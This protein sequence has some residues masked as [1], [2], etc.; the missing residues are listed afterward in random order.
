MGVSSPEIGAVLLGGY[1]LEAKLGAAT[2]HVYRARRQRDGKVVV[3]RLFQP[4]LPLM[5]ADFL[6]LAQTASRIRHPALASVEAYG[7]HGDRSCFIISEFVTGLKLD[8]WADEVGIP[9]MVQVIELVRHV[10]LGLQAAARSGLAHDSLNPR[11]VVVLKP[12]Q[13][14][15]PRMP[16]KLLDLGVPAFL[17]PRE[18]RAQAVRF[19]APE[20][21]LA[22]ASED[23][24]VAFRCT[25]TMNVYSCGCLLYYLCTGGPPYPGATVAELR[26]AHS[27]GR[28]A[29]PLRI[30]P[31]ISP[32]FNTLILRALALEPRERF[33]TV[34]DLAE[35][36]ASVIGTLSA[37]GKGSHPPVSV[38]A[39][40][41][42][43]SPPEPD[44]D[45]PPTFKTVRPPDAYVE[46]HVR[47]MEGDG[48]RAMDRNR[49]ETLELGTMH[50]DD[51]QTMPPGPATDSDAPEAGPP[52]GLFS[53]A[54]PWRGRRS[55]TPP[56]PRRATSDRATPLALFS[57][58]APSM[59]APL[60]II[61]AKA[62]PMTSLLVG[63][64]DGSAVHRSRQWRKQGVGRV[65]WP[66]SAAACVVAYFVGRL[67]V[68]DPTPIASIE[69]AASGTL[70]PPATPSSAS[71]KQGAQA[72]QPTASAD[73]GVPPSRGE[74]DLP[75]TAAA[76]PA[77]QVAVI[78]RS[79]DRDRDRDRG[80]GRPAARSGGREGRSDLSNAEFV[81]DEVI[82]VRPSEPALIVPVERDSGL[83]H[84]RQASVA[85]EK[86]VAPEPSSAK[87]AA[88]SAPSPTPRPS[89]R[90]EP[91]LPLQA[92]VQIQGVAVRGSLPTSLVR[93]AVE[94]IRPQLASCYSRAA[95]AAGHNGFGELSVEVQI[96]ERGRARNPHANGAA[97]PQLNACVADAASKLVSEKAPDTGTVNASWKVAFTP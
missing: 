21:L 52:I 62:E 16:V 14:P 47:S 33:A 34:G 45:E 89:P 90:V 92:T 97:L 30:N 96:D 94:R 65:V 40:L 86:I 4:A 83:P 3:A 17:A 48:A 64:Y 9:P 88:S 46:A 77:A 85:A 41:P 76:Q 59:R 39:A 63:P 72:P 29:P 84:G 31:Q 19:M 79:R 5:A 50:E 78:D 95:H 68:A 37:H 1:V 57:E 53:S 69:P 32:A 70:T 81:K 43:T 58:P 74:A 24:S 51:A 20:Q 28:M 71:N 75:N 18:P 26:A 12:S 44:D 91:A 60:N 55:P 66:L 49:A 36:L 93:R 10:C 13:G 27:A 7:R 56:P 22:L 54:P 11:N 6:E 25:S 87:L 15:G 42:V 67:F 35:A 23:R 61:V 80:R 2:G 82:E 38:Q 73:R 8:E